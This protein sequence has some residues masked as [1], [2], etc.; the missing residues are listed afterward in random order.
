MGAS[1]AQFQFAA[2]IV[3]FLVALA[4]LA[5]LALRIELVATRPASAFWL[6]LGLSALGA[7]AFVHGALMP[8]QVAAPTVIGLRAGGA[9]ALALAPLAAFGWAGGRIP[10]GL[11]RAGGALVAASAGVAAT[12]SV[13]ATESLLVAGA[14]G[15]GGAVINA[16]RRMIG[17]RLAATAAGTLLLIVVV[18]SAALSTVLSTTVRDDALRRVDSRAAVE[19]TTLRDA[20]QPDLRDAKVAAAS[21][22]AAFNP[23][24]PTADAASAWLGQLS[25][26]FFSDVH[27][28]FVGTDGAVLATSPGF[29]AALGNGVAAAL[30]R[31]VLVSK[32][33]QTANGQGTAG[34]VAGLPVEVGAYPAEV[35]TAAGSLSPIGVAVAV[36][37]IDHAYLRNQASDDPTLTLVLTDGHRVLSS[38]PPV[39]SISAPIARLAAVALGG[40][41]PGAGAETVG[42]K[43]VSV[44]PVAGAGGTGV[45]ALVAESPTT[46]FDNSRN[47]LFRTLFLIALGG[48]VLAFLLSV[49]ASDR[50]SR[51]LESLTAAARRIS[52]GETRVR[53]G[54]SSPDEIGSPAQAFDSMAESIEE[55]EGA[56][57]LAAAEEARLRG[58]LQSVVGGMAEALV[59]VDADGR[60]TDF[61]RAAELLSGATQAKALGRPLDTVLAARLEDGRTVAAAVAE[62]DRLPFTGAG[63][64]IASD[65]APVPVAVSAAPLTGPDGTAGGAVL[66][67][68]DLR[69]ELELERMKTEFLSRIGHE[70]RT[71]LT[72]IVG[73][74]E[75]LS[76]RDVDPARARL[77]QAEIL[78]QS[79][80]LMRTVEMLEFF[81]SSGGNRLEVDR[82]PMPARVIL[83]EAMDRWAA[84]VTPP[85]TLVRK[86]PRGA[87]PV[88]GDRR[89]VGLALDELI[90]N[91]VKFSPEG[92]KVVLEAAAGDDSTVRLTVRDEGKGMS[93]E[94]QR[95]A[96]AEFV[97]GDSS[98]TRRFGGLG[99]GLPL[100]MRVAEGHGG[101]VECT[102]VVGKGSAVAL[103]LPA[104]PGEGRRAAGRGG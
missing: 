59:A 68:R 61:N 11:L 104:A 22:E 43:F 65:G 7:S 62:R 92:G 94:E 8:G 35:Q 3:T 25:S 80:R 15:V 12:H 90:D 55:K 72:A 47:S 100:V 85:H 102:S 50:I 71:P 31:S 27:L 81:A 101:R 63:T 52:G 20:W 30:G 60:I 18:L 33:L 70:L 96:F 57:R 75:I 19:A 99:L 56:L 76:R 36:T 78:D 14:I 83:D 98:D 48:S 5:V 28:L 103:V 41:A 23:S 64:V 38:Y 82:Q 26:Q 40:G 91:A 42:A 24:P 32:A 6:G 89:W 49:L 97:Q 21:A 2:E 29:D 74:T 10:A 95:A 54:I 44:R 66:L 79:R 46:L 86:A 88:L 87:P 67:V 9:L 34:V 73:F 84:K 58:R 13:L 17:A 37:A 53:T 51:G 16:S 77:W 4:G 93:E 39:G 45:M 69:P 1:A